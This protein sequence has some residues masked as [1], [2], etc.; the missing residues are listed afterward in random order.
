[1]LLNDVTN[2]RSTQKRSLARFI[3]LTCTLVQNTVMWTKCC[4]IKQTNFADT[5][6]F[7]SQ[8]DYETPPNNI[9]Q[10]LFV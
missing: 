2:T 8:Y 4:T 3:S 7:W 1:M 10:L 9:N 5:R 6:H